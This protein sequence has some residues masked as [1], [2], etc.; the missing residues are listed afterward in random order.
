MVVTLP[1]V[2]AVR[3]ESEFLALE[4]KN[5][6][7]KPSTTQFSKRHHIVFTGKNPIAKKKKR[8][9]FFSI[10]CL[11]MSLRNC[12]LHPKMEPLL[13]RCAEQIGK[14]IYLFVYLFISF[15]VSAG[16][17]YLLDILLDIL[18][19]DILF[20]IDAIYKFT[21]FTLILTLTIFLEVKGW[22]ESNQGRLSCRQNSKATS[23]LKSTSILQEL[24]N[25]FDTFS[26]SQLIFETFSIRCCHICIW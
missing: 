1:A 18:F 16:L 4:K 8:T 11:I 6:I 24:I 14:F 21:T 23:P 3:A 12:I 17:P 19:L 26:F 25:D 7:V 20:F 22:P 10:L 5:L 15:R 2:Q 13:Y 9:N